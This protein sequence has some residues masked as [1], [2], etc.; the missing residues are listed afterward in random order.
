MMSEITPYPGT[1]SFKYTPKAI[2]SLLGQVYNQESSFAESAMWVEGFES[3][4]GAEQS[5]PHLWLDFQN[6][7]LAPA[8]QMEQWDLAKSQKQ[9][10]LAKFPELIEKSLAHNLQLGY[11]LTLQSDKKEQL[12]LVIPLGL[13][14]YLLKVVVKSGASLNLNLKYLNISK[15]SEVLPVGVLVEVQAGAH[16]TLNEEF[17]FEGKALR[18]LS[19][20]ILKQ[21]EFKH[22]ASTAKDFEYLRN[23]VQ[24]HLIEEGASCKLGGAFLQQSLS[25]TESDTWIHHHRPS[26]VSNQLYKAVLD[27]SSKNIFL[28]HVVMDEGVVGANAGQMVKALLLSDKA[29]VDYKP[30]LDI[31]CDDVKAAHG[32]AISRFQ[33]EELF[34]LQTRGV[35]KH[36]ALQLLEKGFLQEARD[37]LNE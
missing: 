36:K 14:G 15:F 5:L 35:E 8:F 18:A 19:V 25:V 21:G 22:L 7:K 27:G 23:Q 31:H 26:T 37:F 24:V 28:G 30:Y 9:I 29:S 1:E 33:D 11:S 6:E 13:K 12:S 3:L 16:L 32:A 17:I 10:E 20:D 34:Y 2:K 4:I